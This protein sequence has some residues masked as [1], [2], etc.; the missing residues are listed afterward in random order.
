MSRRDVRAGLRLAAALALLTA[1]Q[2]D[3]RPAATASPLVTPTTTAPAFEPSAVDVVTGAL[4]ATRAQRTAV[5]EV[6]SSTRIGPGRLT[7][8]RKGSYDLGNDRAQLTQTM[9]A[10]PPGLLKQLV[11]EDVDPASL[12]LRTV[13][14]GDVA[15]LQMPAWPSHL[16]TRWL[17][18]TEDDMAKVKVYD[19]EVEVLPDMVAMLEEAEP[20]STPSSDGTYHVTVPAQ[21]AIPAFPLR[22]SWIRLAAAGVD[23][24]KIT[25]DVE[26]E[27]EVTAGLVKQVRYDPIELFRQA[28]TMA[29][30]Q[31]IGDAVTSVE[32]TITLTSQGAP[33]AIKVPAGREVFTLAELERSR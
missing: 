9:E 28:W 33:L 16:R 4:E 2:G 5:F 30:Q 29:G 6:E 26:V 3:P 8:R 19:A 20:S 11:G 15:Y 10:Q 13:A 27:V 22:S 23:L 12:T 31:Q 32:T 1:C 14:T 17:R 18:F 25:G 7:A 21:V 24:T